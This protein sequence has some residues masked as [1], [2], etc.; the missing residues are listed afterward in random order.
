VLFVV[1]SLF[2]CST[3]RDTGRPD[4]EATGSTVSTVGAAKVLRRVDELK[5]FQPDQSRSGHQCG[6]LSVSNGTIQLDASSSSLASAVQTAT[7]VPPTNLH[8][9][10][11]F[12]SGFPSF[13][14]TDL[15]A[16]K[17]NAVVD[18]TWPV[19]AAS[20]TFTVE[21]NEQC[22]AATLNLDGVVAQAPTGQKV[23]LGAITIINTAWQW[24]HPF[25]CHLVEGA[26]KS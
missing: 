26:L 7:I 21:R 3:T 2:G 19:S 15:D 22:S 20:A 24:W 10:V 16:E 12:G 25:E 18:E 4:P 5:S 9:S 13:T 14:C 8:L 17:H 6:D 11:Q 1:F 23:P